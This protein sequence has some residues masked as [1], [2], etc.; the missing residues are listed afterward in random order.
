MAT[1]TQISAITS[2][3][4]KNLKPALLL[5]QNLI[6]AV[7]KV[8]HYFFYSQTD[9][10][11]DGIKFSRKVSIYSVKLHIVFAHY[12]YVLSPFNSFYSI[13]IS[14][15]LRSFNVFTGSKR[16]LAFFSEHCGEP[17]Q[18]ADKSSGSIF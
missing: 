14:L 9:G 4:V 8:A 2:G 3:V 17:K 16:W 6:A 13:L 18:A 10:C 15:Y 5:L 7:G 11:V 12:R 1:G